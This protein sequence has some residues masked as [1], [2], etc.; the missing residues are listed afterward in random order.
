MQPLV[1][2][3]SFCMLYG[4]H[5]LAL[6]P[7]VG[8]TAATLYTAELDSPLHCKSWNALATVPTFV[9]KRDNHL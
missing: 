4:V 9:Y 6:R 1:V 7:V 2:S 8:A 3:T 5:L